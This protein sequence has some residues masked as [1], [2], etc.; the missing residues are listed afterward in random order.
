VAIFKD[1]V[2]D[3]ITAGYTTAAKICTGDAAAVCT[4]EGIS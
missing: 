2:K 4:S 3:V 1:N